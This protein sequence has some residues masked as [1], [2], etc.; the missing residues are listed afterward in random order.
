LQRHEQHPALLAEREIVRSELN[1]RAQR[2]CFYGLNRGSV[3][4]SLPHQSS[5][6]KH[7]ECSTATSRLFAE[8][9]EVVA[10]GDLV[11]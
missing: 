2:E 11:P 5:S 1:S 8:T 4:R 3:F 7:R 6:Y 10:G 9:G